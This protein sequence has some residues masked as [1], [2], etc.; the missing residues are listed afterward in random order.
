MLNEEQK[1]KEERHI[2]PADQE[3][4]FALIAFNVINRFDFIVNT[5]KIEGNIVNFNK[6]GL[7]CKTVGN[8]FPVNP[9]DQCLLNVAGS[10]LSYHIK[11]VKKGPDCFV[12]GAELIETAD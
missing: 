1:R 8:K 12:F 10:V 4:Y 2:A 7:C 11:W 6:I 9:N 3:F 5:N